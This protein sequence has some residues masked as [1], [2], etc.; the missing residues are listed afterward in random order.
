VRATSPISFGTSRR[1]ALLAVEYPDRSPRFD[2]APQRPRERPWPGN[3]RE[4]VAAVERL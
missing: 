4:L 3:V 1:R 2:D